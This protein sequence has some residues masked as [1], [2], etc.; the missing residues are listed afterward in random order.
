M[1]LHGRTNNP[2]MQLRCCKKENGPFHTIMG[3]KNKIHEPHGKMSE[4]WCDSDKKK[5]IA[6]SVFPTRACT[7]FPL[8]SFKFQQIVTFYGPLGTW[9]IFQMR[10]HSAT[11]IMAPRCQALFPS[12]GASLYTPLQVFVNKGKF[13][14]RKRR[15]CHEVDGLQ[16]FLICVPVFYA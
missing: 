10:K 1:V 11:K 3:C 16:D 8:G 7:F 2:C 14:I 5:N 6:S 9:Y 4:H 13:W 15:D 12:F